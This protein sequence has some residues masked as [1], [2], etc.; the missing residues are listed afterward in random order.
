MAKDFDFE[1]YMREM[2]AMSRTAGNEIRSFKKGIR[3]QDQAHAERMAEIGQKGALAKVAEEQRQNPQSSVDA[4][5]RDIANTANKKLAV[6]AVAKAEI[7]KQEQAALD[8]IKRRLEK[9]S[10]ARSAELVAGAPVAKPGWLAGEGIWQSVKNISNIMDR[11]AQNKKEMLPFVGSLFKFGSEKRAQQAFK[12]AGVTPR[13]LQSD[14]QWG[15]DIGEMRKIGTQRRIRQA[16]EAAMPS[17]NVATPSAVT[18]PAINTSIV[19]KPSAVATPVIPSG[20]EEIANLRKN[21]KKNNP[22]FKGF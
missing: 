22:N 8:P 4:I 5:N 10:T 20:D 7:P 13:D 1:G 17:T 11:P 2:I 15:A 14:E 19:T 3:K 18:M 9:G 6:E 12:S 16:T 21:F